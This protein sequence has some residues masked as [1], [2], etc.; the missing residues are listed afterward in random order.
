MTLKLLSLGSKENAS[1]AIS[2]IARVDIYFEIEP[3]CLLISVVESQCT[4]PS[5]SAGPYCKIYISHG[6]TV[7]IMK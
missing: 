6:V 7:L 4:Q 5:I 3:A 1:A 2:L